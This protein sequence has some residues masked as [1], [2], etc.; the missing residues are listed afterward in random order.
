MCT[1]ILRQKLK[2]ASR[3]QNNCFASYL[4]PSE[5]HKLQKLQSA[6]I[7]REQMRTWKSQKKL[8]HTK[9]APT[10]LL[11]P[12]YSDFSSSVQASVYLWT[13]KLKHSFSPA[14]QNLLGINFLHQTWMEPGPFSPLASPHQPSLLP[15]AA[16]AKNT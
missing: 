4:Q 6:Q 10:L 9:F 7:R 16:A 14:T 8:M 2:A 11:Q 1:M 13:L 15:L 5:G 3:A 12:L